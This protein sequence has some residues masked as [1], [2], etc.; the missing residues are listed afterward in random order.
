[1]SQNLKSPPAT[2][3]AWE[4]EGGSLCSP[5]YAEALGVRRVL[6]ETFTVGGYNYANLADA[7]AQAHRMAKLERELL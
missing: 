4:N 7:V 1:M 5:S 2:P 6:T 3:E